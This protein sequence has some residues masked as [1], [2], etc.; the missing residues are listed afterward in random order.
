MSEVRR[1]YTD[2][3]R[4]PSPIYTQVEPKQ[5][6]H[7][8]AVLKENAKF[9]LVM[10]DGLMESSKLKRAYSSQPG[11]RKGT[12]PMHLTTLSMDHDTAPKHYP[13]YSRHFRSRKGLKVHSRPANY[14][15]QFVSQLNF[16]HQTGC[17]IGGSDLTTSKSTFQS[18]PSSKI[19][20][21]SREKNKENMVSGTD[22]ADVVFESHDPAMYSSTYRRSYSFIR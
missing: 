3:T 18:W 8:R 13:S 6:V 11:K 15:S 20:A 16:E 5:G 22:G 10:E 7:S 9:M 17:T 12:R 19:R 4:F 2:L 1:F 14:P 21:V